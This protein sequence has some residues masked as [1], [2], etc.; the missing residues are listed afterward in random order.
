VEEFTDKLG[1]KVLSRVA[2][3]HDTYYVYDDLDNLRYVLPPL[4]SDGIN[5]TADCGETIGAPLDLYGY[6]YHYDGRKRCIG[7]KL[8]GCGWVNMAYDK[9]DRLVASQDGNQ[10]AK[11]QW[12]INK[13]DV[14]GRLIYSGLANDSRTGSQMTADCAGLLFT[15]TT[16]RSIVPGY[17]CSNITPATLLTVNYY[18]DYSFL[19]LYNPNGMLTNTNSSGYTAPDA[20]PSA[21]AYAKTMLTGTRT[22]HLDDPTKFEVTAL[23]YDKYSRVVQTRATNHLGGYDM[24]YNNLDFTGK[25]NKTL[26]THGING[27]SDT[28]QELYTYTYDKAQR[29]LTT[30]HSLNGGNTVTLV[31]NTYD[32]LG[33]VQTKTL[34]GVD[35]TNYSYNVRNWV[36][37]I[38]GSRFI[39]NIYYNKNTANLPTFTASYNGNIAGMQWSIPGENLTYTHTYNFIYDNL[40]RFTNTVYFRKKG[41]QFSN[42]GRYDEGFSYDK[43]GNINSLFRY[44]NGRLINDLS[45]A[46]TGNQMLTVN[47]ALS[48]VFPYGSEA[49]VDRQKI[50]VEYTYDANGSMTY[51]AN[52]GISTIRYNVLNLPDIIQFAEGHQNLYTYD[53][54]GKKLRLNNYTLH[55]PVNV[56]QGNISTLPTNSSD[57]TQT[58]TDYVGNMIY[59]NGSLKEIL[60]PEGY[61]QSGTYYYYLKDHLGDN[62]VT[63]NSSGTVIEKS[64]YYPSGMRF[65]PESTSNSAAL[66]YRYNGKELEAM[67]GLN[68]YDYG[69]RRRGAGLPI[70]TAIDPLA[71]KY[72]SIS[73]YVYC[74]NN[75]LKY[76]DPDGKDGT[77]AIK[78]NQIT[79]SANV[80]LYGVGATKVVAAQMQ[81]DINKKWGG[82]YNAR[83][84]NG[85]SSFSVAVNVKVGLYDG[86]EKADPFVIPESWNPYNRDNFIE[87]GAGDKR[88]Y[89]V[90]GDEGE[91]RSQGRDRMTLAQDDPAPHE[92]GHLLGLGD[93]YTDKDGANKGWEQNIMGNSQKGNVEQRNI[94]GILKDAMKAYEKWVQDPQ[95]KGKEFK[96]EIN[97]NNPHN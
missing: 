30:T 84:S 44:E 54:G 37:D 35:A 71:E 72:Y 31:S 80:Y 11:G 45:F 93:Q 77:I 13:Y 60:L 79:I 47:D 92:V 70:W 65:A 17:T 16:G 94:D 34:G 55:N 78:G 57:Y 66:P 14:F 18:D 29:L 23:Y 27:A 20:T 25:P 4:V 7:K 6:I 40:N 42:V 48:I 89:V 75:P 26:K 67:N 81:S 97:T 50:P 53:A 21:P 74:M 64:H 33:R 41:S 68:Q 49:F 46:Y 90:G 73:P 39:E 91:W 58:V 61:W 86:K 87:I 76:L 9:A 52:S 24:T 1:R 59:E 96:Y 5:S 38:T 12:T 3:D 10:S 51:D 85:K 88:S 43:M 69:A 36:T 82:T 8:P 22:Y 2:G 28:Y 56:P 32:P 62:R 83:T 95:N 19:S 15:E 63:I